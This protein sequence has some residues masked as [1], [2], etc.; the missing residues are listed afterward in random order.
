MAKSS[1]IPSRY[2]VASGPHG[3]I[4]CAVRVNGKM[5]AREFLESAEC[6]RYLYALAACFHEIVNSNPDD[7]EVR[8]KPLKKTRISEFKKGQV[9]IFCYRDGTAWVLTNGFLKK[10][11][12][13][14]PGLIERAERIRMEDLEIAKPRRSKRGT[15]AAHDG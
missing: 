15:N 7:D 14:P 4:E 13:T 8:P 11:E 1:A 2:V 5:E 3:T 10:S 9:R 6:K 12:K